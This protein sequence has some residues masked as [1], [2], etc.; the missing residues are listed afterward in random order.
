MLD[1]RMTFDMKPYHYRKMGPPPRPEA[2][3]GEAP[4]QEPRGGTLR[5]WSDSRAC[6]TRVMR[7]G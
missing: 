1:L 5:P 3:V 2:V 6:S 7:L 4:R